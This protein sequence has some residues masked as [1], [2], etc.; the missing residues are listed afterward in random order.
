M[1]SRV[2]Y[3]ETERFSETWNGTHMS[4]FSI[5]GTCHEYDSKFACIA[6]KEHTIA[7]VSLHNSENVFI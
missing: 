7:C 6:W 1:S 3:A 4:I 2:L 5:K